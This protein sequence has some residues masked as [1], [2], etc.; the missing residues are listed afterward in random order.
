MCYQ[1]LCLRGLIITFIEI[2]QSAGK[3]TGYQ[4]MCNYITLDQILSLRLCP[5][6]GIRNAKTG[7]QL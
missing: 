1:T 2:S 7:S 5:T 6:C 3:G 4:I